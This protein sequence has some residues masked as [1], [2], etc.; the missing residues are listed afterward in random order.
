VPVLIEVDPLK[1]Q[2]R[3]KA[4]AEFKGVSYKERLN[5]LI[6]KG[7]R[8]ELTIQSFITGKLLIEVGF[9]PET[10][11]RLT[12]LDPNHIELPRSNPKL[13]ALARLWENWILK[14]FKIVCLAPW[15]AL[16]NY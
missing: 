16:K 2:V 5:T 11:I 1:W 15:P 7:L 4:E 6:E 14:K 10:P 12:G 3:E 9:R 8:A 13:P